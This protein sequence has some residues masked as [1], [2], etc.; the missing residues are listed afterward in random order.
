[1]HSIGRPGASFSRDSLDGAAQFAKPDAMFG[2]HELEALAQLRSPKLA[3]S[4]GLPKRVICET[5]FSPESEQ[6]DRE[7]DAPE[8]PHDARGNG[9]H[10]GVPGL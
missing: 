5:C 2:R 6:R 8:A 3:K 4:V 10:G 7:H 9:Q 1:M